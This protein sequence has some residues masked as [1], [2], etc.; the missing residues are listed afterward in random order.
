[1]ILLGIETAINK[2]SKSEN[3]MKQLIKYTQPTELITNVQKCKDY[4]FDKLKIN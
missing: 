4:N 2:Q 3:S 1:M